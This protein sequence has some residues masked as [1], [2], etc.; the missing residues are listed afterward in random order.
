MRVWQWW[1][2]G[3]DSAW[4]LDLLR[5]D[6][7]VEVTGLVT[8]VTADFGRVSMHAVRTEIVR[9]QAEAAGLPLHLVEIP[10]P[11]DNATY[12]AAARSAIEK[13][14]SSGVDMMAFGDLFLEDVRSYREALLAGSGVAP[15]FPLWGVDTRELAAAMIAGGLEATVTCVDPQQLDGSFAGRAYDA[16]FLADLPAG[17]DPC[18]ENGEFHTCVTSGP[19]FA[20]RVGVSRGEIVTR[21][22]FVFADLKPL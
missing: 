22:G 12:E 20:N 21:D 19:M 8:T 4:A 14:Q 5:Q 10:Y 18:G 9:R 6:P 3:K 11:C 17:I 7:G 1:S 2:S 13:A 16:A 15:L